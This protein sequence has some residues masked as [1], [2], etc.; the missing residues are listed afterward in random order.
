MTLACLMM[1]WSYQT[2]IGKFRA[3]MSPE[4]ALSHGFSRHSAQRRAK[5]VHS[6]PSM[7]ILRWTIGLGWHNHGR[8]L[9]IK[10]ILYYTCFL[11][12]YNIIT[13]DWS[14]LV[15]FFALHSKTNRTRYFQD[16]CVRDIC[17]FQII[18]NSQHIHA[19]NATTAWNLPFRSTRIL[20]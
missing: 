1:I 6:Q 19:K 5:T 17:G 7:S 12:Q 9:I 20:G 18:C 14:V 16:V 2:E 13:E 4:R 3:P 8:A 11:M 10:N 15:L